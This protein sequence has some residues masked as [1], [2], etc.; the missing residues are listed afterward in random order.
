MPELWPLLPIV[1]LSSLLLGW[2][3]IRSGYYA[4]PGGITI[5]PGCSG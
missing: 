3:R 5:V 4:L 1:F 2:L